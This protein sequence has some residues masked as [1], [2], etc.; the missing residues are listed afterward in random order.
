MI[1]LVLSNQRGGVAKTTT[2]HTLGRY[3]ADQGLKVLLIDTDPQGSLGAVLG[4]KPRRYLHQFVVH[5]YP[6]AE[7]ILEAYPGIHIL[8]SNRETAVTEQILHGVVGREMVFQNL[9]SKID[10]E[11]DVVLIDV[12][13]SISML[14]NCALVYA[15]RMLI[16]VAMDP[17]SLQGV[18]ANVETCRLLN[19]AFHLD[20]RAAAILPVI[21]DRRLQMTTI[22]MDS[23]VEL[24]GRFRI[25]VLHAIR[26]DAAVTKASRARQ[27]LVDYD[28]RSRAVEDYQ[29]ACQELAGL[30]QEQSSERALR[31]SA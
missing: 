11:Y 7:C 29:M 1:R 15:R 21:M 17:L 4:L 30:L 14:Q 28:P 31:I 19:A 16:P 8:C 22:V 20:V 5:N 24:A 10:L 9:F 6:F 13:P 26:V 3:F 18:G 12:A 2:T 27:F 25:P 23:L